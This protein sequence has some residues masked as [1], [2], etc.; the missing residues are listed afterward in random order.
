MRQYIIE[1]IF[2]HLKFTVGYRNFLLRGLKK[3]SAEFK[4]DVYWI[5]SKK[6]AEIGNKACNG[7]R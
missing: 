1:S 2:G 5:E 6:D 3:V 7:I 4:T